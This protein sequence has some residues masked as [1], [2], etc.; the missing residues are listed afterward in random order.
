M[1]LC[2]EGA[3]GEGEGDRGC[4]GAGCD[5]N[6]WSTV[7]RLFSR[8][9]SM[10]LTALESIIIELRLL[11]RGLKLAVASMSSEAGVVEPWGLP[12]KRRARLRRC[13]K[14]PSFCSL[15]GDA[16]VLCP[17]NARSASWRWRSA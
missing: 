8:I 1:Y 13:E 5:C 4:L 16:S 15:V 14:K 7:S 11:C 9:V 12:D 2:D 6:F 10:L 17:F 3:S